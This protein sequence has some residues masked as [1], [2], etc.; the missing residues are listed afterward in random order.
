MYNNYVTKPWGELVL[1]PD[2][3]FLRTKTLPKVA[4]LDE[5]IFRCAQ[6]IAL[7]VHMIADTQFFLWFFLELILWWFEHKKLRIFRDFEDFR[8]FTMG[9]PREP[10]GKITKIL[11]IP[12]NS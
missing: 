12:K 5:N 6:C 9:N 1:T 10:Y 4:K 3:R 11:E 2:L 8:D 7:D